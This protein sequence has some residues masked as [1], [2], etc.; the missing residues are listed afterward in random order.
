MIWYTYICI[1]T[2]INTYIYTYIHIYIWFVCVRVCMYVCVWICFV[3]DRSLTSWWSMTTRLSIST[4]TPPC[5]PTSTR[6]DNMSSRNMCLLD[7][8]WHNYFSL[9]YELCTK[10]LPRLNFSFYTYSY[11]K[12]TASATSAPI[13]AWKCIVKLLQ[14]DRQADGHERP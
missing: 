14:T 5:P 10:F 9:F 12:Q 7:V 6:N 11:P 2:Y 1:Y 13:G 3:S 4:T 8:K